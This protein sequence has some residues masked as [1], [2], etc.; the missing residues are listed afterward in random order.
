MSGSNLKENPALIKTP[1]RIFFYDFFC[2]V[3]EIFEFVLT[4]EEVG[5]P[6]PDKAIF[7]EALRRANAKADE[8]VFIGDTWETDIL[9]SHQCGIRSIWL[10]RYGIGAPPAPHITSEIHAFEPVQ[11]VIDLIFTNPL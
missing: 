5:T 3:E 1:C 6:K 7:T 9:G 8:T 10:N 11:K 2:G 4:S